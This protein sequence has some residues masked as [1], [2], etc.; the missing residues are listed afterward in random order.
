MSEI[1]E[2]YRK[3]LRAFDAV[4]AQQPREIKNALFEVRAIFATLIA[5]HDPQAALAVGDTPPVQWPPVLP[6]GSPSRD[7]K[8]RFGL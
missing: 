8:E 1:V 3:C 4:A 2:A 7:T 5:A 6:Q